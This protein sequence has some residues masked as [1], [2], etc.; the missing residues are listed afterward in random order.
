MPLPAILYKKTACKSTFLSNVAGSVGRR[1]TTFPPAPGSALIAVCVELSADTE[2]KMYSRRPPVR[3][4]ISSMTAG[5][6]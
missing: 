4:E 6:E 2:S 3:R 1:T 5:E